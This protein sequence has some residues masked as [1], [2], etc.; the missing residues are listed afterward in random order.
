MKPSIPSIVK[1]N[2]RLKVFLDLDFSDDRTG[3]ALY[4]ATKAGRGI[5][6]WRDLMFQKES[7]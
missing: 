6:R 7:I 5:T 1:K 3:F 4:L 2:Y